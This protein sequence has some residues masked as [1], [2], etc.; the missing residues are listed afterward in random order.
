[1]ISGV[2]F[3]CGIL[4]SLGKPKP[5]RLPETPSALMVLSGGY[6]EETRD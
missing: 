2:F 5:K 6:L 1:M 4:E 3:N